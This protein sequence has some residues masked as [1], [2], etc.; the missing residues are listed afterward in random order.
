MYND[1]GCLRDFILCWKY[2]TRHRGI[3]GKSFSKTSEIHFN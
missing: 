3:I 1:V 2:M